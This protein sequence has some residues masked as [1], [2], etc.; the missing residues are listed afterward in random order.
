VVLCVLFHY[1]IHL[2]NGDAPNSHM[3]LHTLLSGDLG[4]SLDQ[5]DNTCVLDGAKY[6]TIQICTVRSSKDLYIKK[7]ATQVFYIR[8]CLLCTCN[9]YM[10]SR[11][12]ED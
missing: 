11:I 10:L 12:A 2:M 6:F 9:S 4:H 5:P 7:Q 3:I 8:E 1:A